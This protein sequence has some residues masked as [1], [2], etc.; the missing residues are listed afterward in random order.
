MLVAQGGFPSVPCGAACAKVDCVWG[1]HRAAA[2]LE[3]ISLR[4]IAI[5]IIWAKKL[6]NWLVLR[7]RRRSGGR[8]YINWEKQL[9]GFF[10]PMHH[11]KQC[12]HFAAL[13]S[14]CPN[15]NRQEVP[16]IPCI[17]PWPQS[18]I[19]FNTSLLIFSI[20]V[21]PAQTKNKKWYLTQ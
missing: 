11:Q 14:F 12:Y 1:S 16:A 18:F 6:V 17:L 10:Q 2:Q 21:I 19:F 5:L 15:F 3:H 7:M 9:N 8:K 20:I 4:V 13:C